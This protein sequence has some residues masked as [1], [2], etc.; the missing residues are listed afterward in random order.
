MVSVRKFAK[1]VLIVLLSF[2][3]I[4]AGMLMYQLRL[5][6]ENL[7]PAIHERKAPMLKKPVAV[8]ASLRVEK[9][10]EPVV[11]ADQKVMDK[12]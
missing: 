9:K 6:E 7:Q 2:A 5:P 3:C 12:Q 11:R 1:S 4:F 8:S 10:T